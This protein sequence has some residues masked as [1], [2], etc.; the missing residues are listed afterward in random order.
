VYPNLLAIVESL[1]GVTFKNNTWYTIAEGEPFQVGSGD[2]RREGDG[3]TFILHRSVFVPTGP[4][5]PLGLH[6]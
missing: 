6:Q 4:A 1:D 5:R 3:T 2:A